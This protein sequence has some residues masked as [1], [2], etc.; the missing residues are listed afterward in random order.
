M[1]CKRCAKLAKAL[2]SVLTEFEANYDQANCE[3]SETERVRQ[4]LLQIGWGALQF[5]IPSKKDGNAYEPW[6]ARGITELAYYK[7]LY[8]EAREE[9]QDM[10][11]ENQAMEAVVLAACF[12]PDLVDS[13]HDAEQFTNEVVELNMALTALQAI[14][15]GKRDE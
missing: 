3:G 7:G 1:S 14:R 10:K 2:K 9:V 5:V 4:K 11:A 12:I 15:G 6:K 8:I 13:L